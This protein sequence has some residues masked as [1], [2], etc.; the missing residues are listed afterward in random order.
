M[1][2]FK[3]DV[4]RKPGILW[5]QLEGVFAI[6]EMA[7]FVSTHNAAIDGFGGNDYKVF[8]DIR[9]LQ[10]LSPECAA[11]FEQAKRY[12]NQHLNF[13]GS[14]VLVSSATIA[15]QHRRT[16][17]TGGVIGTELISESEP[18]LCKHLETVYRKS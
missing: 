13:R 16:S 5:L 1:G 4:R 15:L 3:V 8:C 12:R 18:A 2:T 6:E 17:T 7:A 9:G 11:A 10:P 14:A